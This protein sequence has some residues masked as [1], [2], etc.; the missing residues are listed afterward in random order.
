MKPAEL[1]QSPQRNQQR[2]RGASCFWLWTQM[3]TWGLTERS[4]SA[5]ITT[6]ITTTLFYSLATATTSGCQLSHKTLALLFST[7]FC[8]ASHQDLGTSSPYS[9]DMFLYTIPASWL[10]LLVYAFLASYTLSPL[11]PQ[12]VLDCFRGIFAQPTPWF[13]FAVI[14]LCLY[15]SCAY[16]KIIVILNS[17]TEKD[18]SRLLIFGGSC[19][20]WWILLVIYYW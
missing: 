16:L 11:S 4:L 13:L 18:K 8:G 20:H 19:Q 5:W 6:S 12:Y 17:K 14:D 1:R 2:R 15:G 9:A 10:C 7:T 3:T